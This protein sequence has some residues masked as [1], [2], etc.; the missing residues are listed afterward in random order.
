MGPGL[1]VGLDLGTSG[2]RACAIDETGSVVTEHAATLPPPAPDGPRVEQDADPWWSAACEVLSALTAGIPD[3]TVRAIAVDG[4]SGTLIAADALGRPLAPAMMYNDARSV[5]EAGRIAR[6]APPETG[7][8]GPTSGLAKFL[9][10][11]SRL[12]TTAFRH[13]LHPADWLSGRLTG[14]YGVSDE[15]N[16]L[17]LGYDPVHRVWPGWLDE[18]GVARSRLPRVVPTGT[19]I[20]TLDPSVATMLRLPLDVAVVAGTTDS[21][22]GFLATGA[23]DPGDAVTSLGSTLA[24]KVLS[25]RPVFAPEYGVY[26]H[27]LGD[28]WLAGGASNSGGAVLA[29]YFTRKELD[30]MTTRLEPNRPT[31]LS[32]YPLPSRGERFPFNDPAR[33]PLLCPRPEN[34]VVFFQ[35]MLEGIA[36]IEAEGYRRL[37]TLGAPYPRRVLSVGGGAKNPAWNCIRARRLGIEVSTPEHTG[38]ALGAALLARRGIMLDP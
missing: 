29:R 1:F 26:S 28:R 13:A 36:E 8:L 2:C 31:G 12:P 34:R 32:Y 37:R 14:R 6:A 4:T 10:L 25:P 22:A 27:R 23:S 15:N 38:A 11:S 18:L 33:E 7:A 16:C 5:T 9:W 3:D 20:G 19:P 35:A 17:K 21:I 30:T 24:L